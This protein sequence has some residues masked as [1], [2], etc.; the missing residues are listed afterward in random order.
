MFIQS[1]AKKLREEESRKIAVKHKP[2]IYTLRQKQLL[3]VQSLPKI[4]PERAE[5]LLKRFGSV[6]RIFQASKR[7]VLSVRGLGEKTVQAIL[8]LLETKYAG[9]EQQ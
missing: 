2:K 3:V 6:R 8:E 7:E 4:G 5:A 1:L 9:L